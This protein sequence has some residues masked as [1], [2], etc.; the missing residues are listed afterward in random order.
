[1]KALATFFL[2]MSLVLFSTSIFARNV[3]THV[4]AIA[5]QQLHNTAPSSIQ[6]AGVGY[7]YTSAPIAVTLQNVSPFLGVGIHFSTQALPHEYKIYVQGSVNGSDWTNPIV[8]QL[9]DDL[10][11]WER[12]DYY[13]HLVFLDENTQWLRYSLDINNANLT[14]NTL[15]EQ[16]DLFTV[17]PQASDQAAINSDFHFNTHYK[18]SDDCEMPATVSRTEWDSMCPQNLL[19]GGSSPTIDSKTTHIAVHHSASSTQGITDFA[20]VVAGFQAYHVEVRGWSDIGYNFLIDP[21]GVIYEGRAGGDRARGAHFC[22]KN[23]QIMGVCMIGTFDTS[24]P[25]PAALESL[26]RLLAWKCDKEGINPLAPAYHA[27]SSTSLFG[28]VGHRDACSTTCPGDGLYGLIADVRS[29]INDFLQDSD[30][31]GLADF[32][33]TEDNTDNGGTTNPPPTVTCDTGIDSDNDGV[34]DDEDVCNGGNDTHD[35]DGDTIPDACDTCPDDPFDVCVLEGFFDC[36]GD[37]QCDGGFQIGFNDMGNLITRQK[38][39]A[40]FAGNINKGLRQMQF[41]YINNSSY[42][43]NMLESTAPQYASVQQAYQQFAF[44]WTSLVEFNFGK[45]MPKNVSPAH[46]ETANVLIDE[47]VLAMDDE[48][49]STNLCNLQTQVSVME[50]Q[51]LSA[52]LNLLD[53]VLEG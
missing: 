38:F 34:C 4:Q 6:H 20:A 5:P 3:Q 24:T 25:L 7:A 49:L 11:E 30:N 46:I 45:N 9:D 22:G 16:F 21:N 37:T 23:S 32:C 19:C 40:F 29:Q 18:T 48:Q 12:S 36:E 41:L 15:F 14:P 2:T 52:A 35:A 42:F 8:A 27:A 44:S 43:N 51:S 31:D 17:S 47:M 33:D 1:M 26:A 10:S 28:V 39:V 13:S 53:E 50:N